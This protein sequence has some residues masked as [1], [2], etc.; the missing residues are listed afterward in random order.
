MSVCGRRESIW[1]NTKYVQQCAIRYVSE[2]RSRIYLSSPVFQGYNQL[3][4]Y[5]DNYI[6]KTHKI[7]SPEQAKQFSLWD[8]QVLWKKNQRKFQEIQY[9]IF[10]HFG[11]PKIWFLEK[12]PHW[13]VLTI[14]KFSLWDTQIWRKIEFG[15]SRRSKSAILVIFEA[16][17]F[18]FCRKF[19]IWKWWK[20]Q[21]FLN[22]K[23]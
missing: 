16:L 3:R 1:P 12:I 19:H 21:K 4:C 23:L 2:I 17:T 8:T 20:L 5:R 6:H 22:W 14:P 11:C 18:D 10:G 7:Y 9:C 13:K 15:N